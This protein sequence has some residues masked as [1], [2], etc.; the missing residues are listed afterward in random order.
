MQAVRTPQDV[1]LDAR[2]LDADEL[3]ESVKSVADF[4]GAER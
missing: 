1:R 4:E 2:M 3:A